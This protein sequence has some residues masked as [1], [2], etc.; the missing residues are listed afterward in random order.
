MANSWWKES[1]VYQIYPKSFQD[2][3]NDGIGDIKGI[4]SRLDYIKKLGTDVIW[5]CPVYKSPM[6][7]GGY[8][9][10][11]YFQI[12]E[13]FGTNEDLD[14]LLEKAKQLDIKVLMDL[15]VNHTSDEH[16]WFQEALHNPASKYRDYYIFKEGIDGN[17]PNNWRSYFG[18]SAWEPVPNE[19]NMFY[20][21][22]FTKKQPDLNWENEEVREEIYTM[23]NYWL[24]K[25]LGGFRIDA[26]LNIKKRLEYGIFESDGEDG[27]AFIGHWILNQPG[28]EVWLKEM[29]ER[30]FKPHNSMTV[31][32]ADVPNERL[33][34]YIGEDGYYS[35]VFDFSYTDID[36]PET[37][38]WFKDSQWTWTD[39]RTNIFTNQLV[40]QD[41]GWGALYL[42]NHDQPRSINKYIPEEWINDY[43]KKM[44]ATLFMLLR[45][46]PF[47]YQGQELGMTNIEMASLED[48]DD[49]ATH[50]QYKRALE[51][52]LAPEQALKAVNKRSRD[53]SRTPMQWNTQKNAGF[54][55]S[56]NVWLKVNPNYP[57][58]NAEAQ[59]TNQQSVFNYY[60]Q[61]IELRKNSVYN[62]VLIYGQFLPVKDKN[63]HIL[64][65]ERQLEDKIVLV[66]LNVTATEQEYY[67]DEQYQQVLINNYEDILL[68]QSRKLRLRPFESIVLANYGGQL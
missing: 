3:N 22:A 21:H 17:P 53:N 35:M 28:I 29:R 24:D 48:F 55:T 16:V 9:I 65:Y 43:S 34:E 63:E 51:Y 57:E 26:I 38:E 39:M 68:D 33:D 18:G 36:V 49:V 11:D 30:T 54:S 19:K 8:D 59:L 1:V 50:S 67:V 13:L 4:I 10:S 47:I 46:T 2:S 23:I 41:K 20:L 37:G 32:E 66:I 61:L 12:D 6:D 5:I 45:G 58:L 56:D 52:G 44:L 42:E 40:T 7:D 15:V 14:E 62:D 60:R 27:L 25:G 64:L 31:A